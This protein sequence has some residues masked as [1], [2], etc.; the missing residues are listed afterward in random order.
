MGQKGQ[1]KCQ[2][3]QAKRHI[4]A[5]WSRREDYVPDCRAGDKYEHRDDWMTPGQ[6]L[7]DR[8]YADH[9]HREPRPAGEASAADPPAEEMGVASVAAYPFLTVLVLEQGEEKGQHRQV[10]R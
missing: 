6:A 8:Q 4:H 7:H 3:R 10:D 1:D 5:M 2:Q 9:E